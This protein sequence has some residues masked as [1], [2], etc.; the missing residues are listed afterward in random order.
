M[1]TVYNPESKLIKAG[2]KLFLFE[3]LSIYL[4]GGEII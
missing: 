4:G 3:V 2:S 1:L